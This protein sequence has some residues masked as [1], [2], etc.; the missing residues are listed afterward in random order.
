MFKSDNLFLDEVERT[1][2]VVKAIIKE[3]NVKIISQLDCDG[4]SSASILSK[5]LLRENVNFGLR[6]VKQLKADIIKRIEI[7]SNDFL[8]ISDCGSGQ[9][10]LLSDIF[11]KTQI[12]ILDHHQPIKFDHLNLFHL[13][14]LIWGEEEISASMVCYLLAK[15]LNIR[16]TD[17][18]DLAI[19]GAI[20]DTLDGKWEF[21]GLAKTI[22]TEAETM[23]KISINKGLRI[24][25]QNRPIHQALAYSFDQFI[26]SISGSESQAVQFL[27]ELGISLKTSDEW[28]KVKD[29]TLE[30]QQILAS[31]IIKERIKSENV[32]E[33]IFGEIY[34]FL[35]KP[36]ELQDIREFATLVNACSRIGFVDIAY[37]LCLND[38][39]VLEKSFEILNIYRKLIRDSLNWIR[40][41]ENSVVSTD[42]ANYILAG[43]KIPET[44]IGTITS[45][46]LNSQFNQE[47]AIFGFADSDNGSVKVSARIPKPIKEINI[48]DVLV[49]AVSLTGY[50]AGGHSEAAGAFIPK[51]KEEEFIKIVD[52]ILGDKIDKKV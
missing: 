47:K 48:R 14:P 10:N 32:A 45:I 52:K 3:K 17:L 7:D 27:S 39:S 24:Y 36:D 34:T 49:D 15:S 41:N 2:K 46:T 38:Y 43:N 20:G 35:G 8:I 29:L 1:A 6:I 9:L 40:E 16:N 23:G 50:E 30:E 5:M 26:P 11:D 33:D 21:R 22:L 13:N 44:L 37:R 19:L 12:L 28:K 42:F 4:L 18:V 51:G 31:A 25:G